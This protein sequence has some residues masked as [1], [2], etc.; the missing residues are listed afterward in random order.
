M[1]Q[2]LSWVAPIL[3]PSLGRK[4]IKPGLEFA[5]QAR[6]LRP[7]VLDGGLGLGTLTELELRARKTCM[8]ETSGQFPVDSCG[9]RWSTP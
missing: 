1:E 3:P 7:H 2:E 5:I 6:I 9:R 8:R 4:R